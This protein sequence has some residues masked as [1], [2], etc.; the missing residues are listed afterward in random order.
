MKRRSF[1]TTV[2]VGASVGAAGR[3]PSQAWQSSDAEASAPEVV[4]GMPRRVLGRT[5]RRIS[6]IGYAGF[7][8]REQERTQAECTASL[9]KAWEHGINY[10]DVAPA[11]ADGLCE[12]RMGQGFA[13]ITDFRRE[14]IFLACKTNKRT[15]AEAQAELDRSLKRLKTDYFDLYQLHCLIKPQEDV[16]AAFGKE[17]AMEAILQAQE[18]GKIR[19]LGF[20]AHTTRAA[21]VAMEKFRFDTIMF[22]INF[23]EYFLFG[24]GK[25]VLDL[26][27]QQGAGVLAIK[28]MSAGAW[29][30][31][32]PWEKRPR[33]WWYRTLEE[34]EEINLALRF[35]LSQKSVVAGIPPAWLDL[36]ERAWEAGKSFRPVDDADMAKLR[37]MAARVGSVFQSGEL[38]ARPGW[39]HPHAR[40]GPHEGCPGIMS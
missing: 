15:K 5:G 4:A 14:E 22:P 39:P 20:S 9:R 18:Q 6:I 28:P 32:V 3:N 31:D 21:L 26:A 24:F 30:A 13:D 8:L 38:A 25:K 29:P 7:A 2:A 12:E 11:Y 36:A 10:F 37:D 40:T 1:L 33:K 27:E 17:G 34:Q 19:H 35:T 16:E 23:V